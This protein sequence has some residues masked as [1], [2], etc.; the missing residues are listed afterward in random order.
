MKK[1]E[2]FFGDGS[3]L[4]R[5]EGEGA[6]RRGAGFLEKGCHWKR[7]V[8]A[9]LPYRL[10]LPK[11]VHFFTF[12]D[13][14]LWIL[15]L[16]VNGHGSRGITGWFIT[17]VRVRAHYMCAMFFEKRVFRP[18]GWGLKGGGWRKTRK[19][20]TGSSPKG[21]GIMALF[22]LGIKEAQKKDTLLSKK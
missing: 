10:S 15:L 18:D 19:R 21:T 12:Y 11:T 20:R 14:V 17:R 16:G 6:W 7:K 1:R 3:F 5:K 4:W 22:I 2:I 8:S 9:A 13:K